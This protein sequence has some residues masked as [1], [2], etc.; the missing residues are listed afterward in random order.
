MLR[1]PKTISRI[2][3]NESYTRDD[4]GMSNAEVLMF[5]DKVLKIQD[6]LIQ[7]E[8]EKDVL[9]WLSNYINTPHVLAYETDESKA[10][11]LM[12]KLE[13]EM[14][15]IV[16]LKPEEV[17]HLLAI[18]IKQWWSIDPL[19]CPFDSSLK[20]KLHEAYQNILND[21]VDVSQANEET[22]GESGFKDPLDLYTWL[23]DNQPEEDLVVS[24]GDFTLENIFVHYN[25]LG[26]ID[27][28]KAGRADR[29]HDVALA[30]RGLCFR[31]NLDLNVEISHPLKELFFSL[32][33]IQPDYE[34]LKYY[35]LL[36][37]LS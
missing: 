25:T 1:F 21:D 2:I 4:I 15:E 13:G 29:Y 31:Y 7:A 23:K 12:S 10:Y 35:I 11:L 18:A 28:G 14:L 26:Y 34:K 19:L 30:Y 37:E 9:I 5:S 32:L 24:H 3:N 22:Y 20:I 27:V 8:R 36:D 17:I 33:N 16:D 6:N